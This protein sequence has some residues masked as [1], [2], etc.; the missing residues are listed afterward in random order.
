MIFKTNSTEFPDVSKLNEFRF[1]ATR[2]I[3]EI[4]T[5]LAKSFSIKTILM[6]QT[7]VIIT[8]RLFELLS[9]KFMYT[10]L[11]VLMVLR[12]EKYCVLDKKIQVK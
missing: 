9:L 4:S 5:P 11:I 2:R 12:T 10:N 3:E 7:K 8:L 6:L 1:I